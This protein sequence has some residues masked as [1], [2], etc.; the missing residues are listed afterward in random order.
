MN[1]PHCDSENAEDNIYCIKCGQ[2]IIQEGVSIPEKY[3][4]PVIDATQL[5]ISLIIDAVTACLFIVAG[6]KMFGAGNSMEMLRS[7][8]GTSVAESFYQEM[9][10]A[11]QGLAFI[12]WALSIYFV[13]RS[14]RRIFER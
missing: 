5:Y 8:S 14:I 12:A 11:F 1:C 2:T 7:V 9:G 4:K 10:R 3:N 6:F 13:S